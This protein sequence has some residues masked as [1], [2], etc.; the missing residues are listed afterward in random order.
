MEKKNK[1]EKDQDP[2]KKDQIKKKVI[3]LSEID[4]VDKEELSPVEDSTNTLAWKEQD[5]PEPLQKEAEDKDSA[6]PVPEE[7]SPPPSPPKED[8]RGELFNDPGEY[9]KIPEERF[10]EEPDLPPQV[11]AVSL[12][13]KTAPALPLYI[14]LAVL[15]LG[16][17]ISVFKNIGASKEISDLKKKVIANAD[18][19]KKMVSEKQRILDETSP[20][21][22]KTTQ[23]NSELTSF[24]T[25]SED[26]KNKNQS[27]ESE[28]T[29]M[30]TS[31]TALQNNM[32]EYAAEVK[33]FATEEIEYY[34]A[35]EE[36]KQNTNDLSESVKQL[37]TRIQVLTDKL[38]TLNKQFTEKEADYVYNMAFLYAKAQMFD[39][40][41]QSFSDYMKLEG[42]NADVH[43]NL[44]IIYDQVKKDSY[45][46]IKHYTEYLRLN[47][48]AG[49]LYEDQFPGEKP[50]RSA[51]GNHKQAQ[52]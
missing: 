23:L 10:K 4:F 40:A 9:D 48:A 35:Y 24:Q 52:C 20:L 8:T 1:D 32:K 11:A 30:K 15:G 38:N 5:I 17:L 26:L 12:P 41:L 3:K 25:L 28:L 18:I 21:R 51:V 22:E 37:N 16:L 44:A 47:P 50:Q 7:E 6:A 29:T 46:A 19:A 42:A 36:E 39:E 31:F 13:V 49:D 34:Y 2:K 45:K 43:Y 27:L 14:I 33:Q